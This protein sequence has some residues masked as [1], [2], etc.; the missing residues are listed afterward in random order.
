MLLDAVVTILKYKKRTIDHAIYI[1]VFA[2]GTVSYLTVSTYDVL[3]T[4]TNENKFPEQT[5]VFKEQ[6]KMKVQKVSVFKYLKFRICQSPFGF[7][8]DQIDH[9]ME[10]V[11]EWFPTAKFLNF[12]VGNH[13]FTSSMM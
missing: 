13:S 4:T 9:I 12:T 11:N 7:S 3:N 5:R 6:F 1:K 10:L 8:I 2:Y